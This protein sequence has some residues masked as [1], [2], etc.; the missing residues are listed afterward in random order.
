M[1][2]TCIKEKCPLYKKFKERCPNYIITGWKVHK[3]AQPVMISDCAPKRTLLMMQTL[4][5]R[6]IG[7]Q[8]SSEKQ[9]NTN[10]KFMGIMENVFESLQTLVPPK[11]IDEL[12]EVID[13]EVE[14]IEDEIV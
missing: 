9:I 3:E 13:S 5:N 8:Q 1:Q 11:K 2:D 7:V 14:E 12:G 6:F 10:V 4:F